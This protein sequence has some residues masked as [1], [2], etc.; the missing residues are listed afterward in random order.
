MQFGKIL[1]RMRREAGM[2][3]EALALELHI[4]RSNVSRLET[5]RLELK[6]S[7][8]VRWCNVTQSQ[9]V[10][11]AFLCGVDG[12]STMQQIM[13]TIAST[14][15]LGTIIRLGGSMQWINIF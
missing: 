9:E 4:S 14:P 5:N 10:L 8:L 2:S 15:F 7:D 12:L 11:I 3:Q 13:D 6:A 1:R